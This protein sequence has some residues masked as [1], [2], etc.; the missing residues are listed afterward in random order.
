MNRHRDFER[1]RQMKAD[2][3]AAAGVKPVSQADAIKARLDQ[4]RAARVQAT[5]DLMFDRIG[6]EN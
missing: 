6:M 5:E 4:L 1:A 3:L 2:S